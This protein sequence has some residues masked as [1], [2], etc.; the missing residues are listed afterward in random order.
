MSED[1]KLEEA[2]EEYMDGTLSRWSRAEEYLSRNANRR[3]A[4][5]LLAV[6]VFALALYTSVFSPPHDFPTEAIVDVPQGASVRDIAETLERE[7]IVRS[8]LWFRLLV[9]FTGNERSLHAGEYLFEEPTG[10]W[11][12][13]Q[14]L[15]HGRYGMEPRRVRIPEGAMVRDIA[16][17]LD[18]ELLRFDKELFT[19]KALPYEGRL[20]PD[21]YFF[22][23]S[24][25]EDTVLEALRQNFD[26]QLAQLEEEIAAF[27]RPLE[28]VL[29]MASILEREARDHE[30]RR[31]IAGVLWRRLDE[32]M[33][34]QV[35]AVFL[36]S[37]G[38]STFQ[39]TL[40]DLRSDS[41]YNTYRYKG[42]PPTPIGSPS[43]SSIRAAI[44][45]IDGGYYYYLA[46][47]TGVTHYSR[48][49]EE[50]LRKK[51]LYLGT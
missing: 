6:F 50:H 38:R 7:R 3:T 44:T 42:L 1:K 29:I 41:P 21:T 27:G 16:E 11:G 10:L 30:D 4:A 36:Y 34:L 51:R 45:P 39:L 48:T 26:A 23:P 49:Y 22:L 47:N 5:I 37:I 32:D 19:A 13:A 9:R 31:R 33:L 35:D 40:E 15:S 2:F 24:A 43:L 12:V 14:A 46:D 28:E 20:F 8:A 25:N 18:E 17:L